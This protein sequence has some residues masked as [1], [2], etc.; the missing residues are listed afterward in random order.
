MTKTAHDPFKGA[1][2]LDLS[3]FSS[4]LP[5][6]TDRPAAEAARKAGDAAG[7][8]SRRPARSATPPRAADAK[9]SMVKLS[10]LVPKT[11]ISGTK[12]QLNLLAP[13]DL[14]LRFKA[15]QRDLGH[16]AQWQTLELAVDALE[17][18][19]QGEGRGHE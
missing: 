3:D 11:T 7:F 16:Q 4:P 13:A 1:D 17:A 8:V 9:S 5:K 2:S 18:Q 19:R 12:S 10:E 14:I 15:L 6:P